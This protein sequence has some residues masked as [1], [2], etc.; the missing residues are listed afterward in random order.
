MSTTNNRIDAA[1]ALWL[2]ATG[3]AA[4]Q[5]SKPLCTLSKNGTVWLRN[6]N[7]HLGFV[8]KAG[9]CYHHIGREVLPMAE[10]PTGSKAP[11][12]QGQSSATSKGASA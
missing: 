1:I 6:V 11:G 12:I 5:P 2:R 7:G 4:M 10:E 8:T 9:K 3:G